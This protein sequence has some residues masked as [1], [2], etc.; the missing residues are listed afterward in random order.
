MQYL[1][2]YLKDIKYSKDS[3]DAIRL[4]TE[5]KVIIYLSTTILG[6]QSIS[7]LFAFLIADVAAQAAKPSSGLLRQLKIVCR[8]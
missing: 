8:I 3:T 1:N 7:A 5:V 2:V 6:L 4:K